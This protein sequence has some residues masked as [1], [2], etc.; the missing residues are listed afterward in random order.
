MVLIPPIS[1]ITPH[2]LSFSNIKIFIYFLTLV[3]AIDNT[4]SH[5]K[6]HQCPPV[7]SEPDRGR[8]MTAAG[9]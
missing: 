1:L 8:T 9:P 6:N 3:S 5:S 7:V 2:P 4:H